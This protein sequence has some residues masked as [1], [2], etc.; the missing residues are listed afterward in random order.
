MVFV[1]L[2]AFELTESIKTQ[3]QKEKEEKFIVKQRYAL[4]KS[5]RN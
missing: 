4:K 5:K 3:R 1:G 2:A